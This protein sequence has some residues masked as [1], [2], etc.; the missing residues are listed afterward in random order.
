MLKLVNQQILSSV[1][2]Y[3]QFL[4]SDFAMCAISL[5]AFVF[6]CYNSRKWRDNLCEDLS[7]H[8]DILRALR[9]VGY[10]IES[11]E[12]WIE[13]LVFG[14]LSLLGFILVLKVFRAHSLRLHDSDHG[15]N[16]AS[17][18]PRR[19]LLLHLDSEGKG[20]SSCDVFRHAIAI[21]SAI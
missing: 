17:I 10:D 21:S 9:I 13:K 4:F 6:N 3:I 8:P 14:G 1:R 20:A 2:L 18:H 15:F 19:C 11:C 12:G 16:S 5:V 7:T